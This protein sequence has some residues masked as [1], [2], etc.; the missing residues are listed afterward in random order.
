MQNIYFVVHY[1]LHTTAVLHLADRVHCNRHFVFYYFFNDELQTN[2]KDG[3][4]P[5]LLITQ[6]VHASTTLMA[7]DD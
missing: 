6:T 3:E 1:A 2:R 4:D 5:F 7:D